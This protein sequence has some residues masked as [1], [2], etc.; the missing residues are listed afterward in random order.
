[1]ASL[2]LSAEAGSWKSC[3]SLLLWA[4]SSPELFRALGLGEDGCRSYPAAVGRGGSRQQAQS[5]LIHPNG[6]AE[7]GWGDGG[8]PKR[9][10]GRNAL[11]VPSQISPFLPLLSA[12]LSWSQPGCQI[13]PQPLVRVLVPKP[14]PTSWPIK[15]VNS[16]HSP[17]F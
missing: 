13:P 15:V 14:V 16:F 4:G 5:E 2:S 9:A 6:I 17:T 1:M 12:G 10:R 11:P 8:L 7:V 3:F